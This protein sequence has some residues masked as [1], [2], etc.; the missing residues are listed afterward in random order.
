MRVMSL[1]LYGNRLGAQ[2]DLIKD[3]FIFN[4]LS[5]VIIRLETPAGEAPLF[6]S[7]KEDDFGGF[8]LFKG[9]LPKR[10][11]IPEEEEIAIFAFSNQSIREIYLIPDKNPFSKSYP[12]L[13]VLWEQGKMAI[14]SQISDQE[15]LMQKAYAN[16]PSLLTKAGEIEKDFPLAS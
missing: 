7:I 15:D 13:S 5:R 9:S 6:L 8:E 1:G 14:G 2:P 16:L 10:K 3:I 4:N 12:I 11:E